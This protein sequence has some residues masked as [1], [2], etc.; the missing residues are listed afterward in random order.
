MRS[1]PGAKSSTVPARGYTE[2]PVLARYASVVDRCPGRA[3]RY[4]G[5]GRKA[6]RATL[7]SSSAGMGLF[8]KSQAMGVTWRQWHQRRGC[9]GS[10]EGGAQLAAGRMARQ[11]QRPSK[12]SKNFAHAA[13]EGPCQAS[14]AALNAAVD[15]RHEECAEPR[16]RG[17][18]NMLPATPGAGPSGR[19]NAARSSN[20]RPSAG[21]A[22]RSGRPRVQSRDRARRTWEAGTAARRSPLA[23]LRL[24]PGGERDCPALAGSLAVHYCRNRARVR[25]PLCYGKACRSAVAAQALVNEAFASVSEM[26]WRYPQSRLTNARDRAPRLRDSAQTSP[27]LHTAQS[28]PTEGVV[29]SG[30]ACGRSKGAHALRRSFEGGPATGLESTCDLLLSNSLMWAR[31]SVLPAASHHWASAV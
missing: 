6:L 16:S 3:S 1:D 30:L 9:N 24:L 20:T 18:Q 12:H 11:S 8:P 29:G 7:V 4:R 17:V 28:S 25:S 15:W 27:S 2:R 5:G 10:Q 14:V 19:P 13:K 22:P 21:G 31:T 26:R 23:M